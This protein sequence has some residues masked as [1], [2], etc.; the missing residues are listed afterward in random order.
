MLKFNFNIEIYYLLVGHGKKN[1]YISSCLLPYI[2]QNNFDSNDIIRE[3]KSILIQIDERFLVSSYLLNTPKG[4]EDFSNENIKIYLELEEKL[5][6]YSNEYGK[7]RKFHE[8]GRYDFTKNQKAKLQNLEEPKKA[9]NGSLFEFTYDDWLNNSFVSEKDFFGNHLLND[10]ENYGILVIKGNMSYQTWNRIQDA[11]LETYNILVEK[12]FRTSESYF[13]RNLEKQTDRK[14]FIENLINVQKECF[15]RYKGVYE[16]VK[17]NKTY[18]GIKFGAKF[19]TA[20]QFK[21]NNQFQDLLSAYYPRSYYNTL[22]GITDLSC[23]TPTKD[24][25]LYC[26]IEYRIKWVNFLEEYLK[27]TFKKT[28]TSRLEEALD[29]I[30]LEGIENTIKTHFASIPYDYFTDS[31]LSEGFFGSNLYS[32]LNGRDIK[33]N[34]EV[35]SA[36]GRAD[37]IIERPTCIYCFEYKFNKSADEALVQILKKKYLDPYRKHGKKLIAIGIN[38]SA[39]LKN[40]ESFAFEVMS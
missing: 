31:K 39:E 32:Y 2:S 16:M 7:G 38:F 28:N 8:D 25:I 29:N 19:I 22:S 18:R 11:Q 24:Q 34:P 4:F 9:I 6:F 26:Q 20:S 10:S 33:S 12:T 14:L 23:E 3:I 40:I 27:M 17:F 15:E 37:K 30:D 13:I 1:D 36:H 5:E 35:H 21:K